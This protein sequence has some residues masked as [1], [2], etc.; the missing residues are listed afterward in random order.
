ML[1]TEVSFLMTHAEQR[2]A[3]AGEEVTEVSRDQHS[4]PETT[5]SE[6]TPHPAPP[7]TGSSEQRQTTV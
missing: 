1:Q 4:S 2:E 3:L 5:G 6:T 7:P